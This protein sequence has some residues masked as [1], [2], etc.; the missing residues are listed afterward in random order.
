MVTLLSSPI[1]PDNIDRAETTFI[2]SLRN[3]TGIVPASV[4]S[5][6]YRSLK[7]YLRPPGTHIRRTHTHTRVSTDAQ[8]L[9]AGESGEEGVLD[10][11]HQQLS[12]AVERRYLQNSAEP[13]MAQATHARVRSPSLSFFCRFSFF[14]PLPP[15]SRADDR[16]CVE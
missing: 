8:S 7:P 2:D 10:F 9:C 6:L 1:Q 3:G 4:W 5:R 14:P 12:F 15:N 11:F 16:M 13:E